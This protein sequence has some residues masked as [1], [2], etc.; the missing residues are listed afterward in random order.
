ME[1]SWWASYFAREKTFF[2]RAR[3]T[4]ARSLGFAFFCFHNLHTRVLKRGFFFDR[5]KEKVTF[6][7]PCLSANCSHF[8]KRGK[9]LIKRPTFFR[10]RS[11]KKEK[12]WTFSKKTPTF[13][14]SLS[15]KVCES[16]KCKIPGMQR[17]CERGTDEKR[18]LY[19][20]VATNN[21][22]FVRQTCRR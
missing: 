2:S 22:S 5:K 13:F 10:K 16:K 7:A 1:H 15:V 11:E 21:E 18:K 17:A 4:R 8:Q 9:K 19:A 3:D 12:R 14:R 20:I 6:K